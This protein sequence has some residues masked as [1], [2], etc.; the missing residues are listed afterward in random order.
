[1]KAEALEFVS[2]WGQVLHADEA[3]LKQFAWELPDSERYKQYA[4]PKSNGGIR[5]IS[6]PKH[7]LKSVQRNLLSIFEK[8][9]KPLDS[10]H[11]FI[12]RRSILTNAKPHVRKPWVLNLDLEKFFPSIGMQRVEQV[13]SEIPMQLILESPE[14]PKSF[15]LQ[16]ITLTAE[17]VSLLANLCC[18]RSLP[19]SE[20]PE[21]WYGLPQGAPTSPILSDMVARKMDE[22]ILELCEEKGVEYTRYAD[23]LSFS[24]L[25]P[26]DF[27]GY[28][29]L[30]LEKGG[31]KLEPTGPLLEIFQQHG[32]RVNAKK[33][34]LFCGKSCKQ[35]TGISVSE[36]TNV[37]RKMIR[38][39]RQDLH[40]WEKYDHDRANDILHQR[41]DYRHKK[42]PKRLRNMLQGKLLF[43]SMVRGK[44]DPVY[45]RFVRRFLA[46]DKRDLLSGT[47]EGFSCKWA[48]DIDMWEANSDWL[49]RVENDRVSFS[50][51][52]DDFPRRSA[53][54]FADRR[55]LFLKQLGN[56]K[57]MLRTEVGSWGYERIHHTLDF[58]QKLIDEF[59]FDRFGEDQKCFLEYL[60]YAEAAYL[61]YLHDDMIETQAHDA[62][63]SVFFRL[64]EI[65]GEVCAGKLLDPAF[66]CH[67]EHIDWGTFFRHQNEEFLSQRYGYEKLDVEDLLSIASCSKRMQSPC[68]SLMLWT[69]LAPMALNAKDDGLASHRVLYKEVIEETP[70]F[71]PLFD[72]V[73]TSC[74]RAKDGKSQSM[75]TGAL[76]CGILTFIKAFGQKPLRARQT[77]K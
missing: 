57:G 62:W 41:K 13:L 30:V 38:S 59:T 26:K 17:I 22:D 48:P 42:C 68:S 34:K 28:E 3:T 67:L 55:L 64:M 75:T 27:N 21:T 77:V 44:G 15:S 45:L 4:I 56:L 10:S 39:I 61:H 69:A 19:E 76:R 36:F 40:L 37:P 46:L 32:F 6:E 49:P 65:N 73:L 66:R 70:N 8:S 52:L 63:A 25:S 2:T 9:Y 51:N 1:M 7:W 35:V 74:A 33:T 20:D 16:S 58:R 5:I 29:E 53:N 50:I 43:L 72:D 47:K 31:R 71:F 24:P 12:Q 14:N 18:F 54:H 23:D 60:L 11:G